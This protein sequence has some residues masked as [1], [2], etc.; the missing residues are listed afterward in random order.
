MSK[1]VPCS[2]WAVVVQEFFEI[3]SMG[4]SKRRVTARFMWE[5]RERK[6]LGV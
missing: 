4:D 5:V 2:D 6:G 1:M 3:H